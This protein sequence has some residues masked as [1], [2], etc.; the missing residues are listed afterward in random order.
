MM[1]SPSRRD[2]DEY[3]AAGG[4]AETGAGTGGLL[5]Q[6]EL[7]GGHEENDGPAAGCGNGRAEEK[8]EIPEEV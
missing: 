3:T 7:C 2:E 8:D 6:V 5:A 1:S 4:G